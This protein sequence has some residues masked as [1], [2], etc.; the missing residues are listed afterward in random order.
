MPK[1]YE[2]KRFVKVGKKFM[3]CLILNIDC[4]IMLMN[5]VKTN[6]FQTATS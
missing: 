2:I 4:I 3:S 1:K 5:K 6:G